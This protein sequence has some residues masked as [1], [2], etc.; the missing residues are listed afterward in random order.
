[1]RRIRNLR[2]FR[3]GLGVTGLRP[4]VYVR[5]GWGDPPRGPALGGRTSPPARS[6]PSSAAMGCDWAVRDYRTIVSGSP[7]AAHTGAM[8]S[9][10]ATGTSATEEIP[11]S[12]GESLA[13][14]SFHP[15]GTG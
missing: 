7:S 13:R 9:R 2:E 1:M 3:F 12:A 15:R 14:S 11:I 8:G 4:T 5:E 10:R 6:L